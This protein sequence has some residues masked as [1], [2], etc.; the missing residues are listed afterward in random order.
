M[1]GNIEEF[2]RR[3]IEQKLGK[4]VQDVEILPEANVPPPKAPAPKP[5]P[6]SLRD[7]SVSEH[8]AQHMDTQEYQER[9]NHLAEEIGH[10]DDRMEDHLQ[11]VF[12]HEV[13]ALDGSDEFAGSTTQKKQ[14]AKSTAAS[15]LDVFRSKSAV[16][17]AVII[18]EIFDRPEHR[19]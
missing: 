4:R 19:W 2:L 12:D 15:L 3:A 17:N 10:A 14:A 8:V 9:A 5:P 7:T 11:A 1:A 6:P 16:R 13:G 18:R